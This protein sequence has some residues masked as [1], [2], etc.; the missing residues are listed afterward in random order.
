[1]T[2]LQEFRESTRQWL[3]ENCPQSMRTTMV[4]DEIVW[5]GRKAEF[6]NPDSKLWLERMAEKGWTCPTWPA[7][8]GGGGLSKD[9]AIV[10]QQELDRIN[11]RPAPDQFWYQHAGAGASGIWQS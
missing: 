7:E 9:E 6:K 2:N 5:G 1:M 11:A 10:L 8:Y 3:E 4:A